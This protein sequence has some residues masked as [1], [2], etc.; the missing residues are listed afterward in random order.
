MEAEFRTVIGPQSA[1]AVP[2]LALAS[3]GAEEYFFRGALQSQ[4]GVWAQALVFGALH[5]PF[6][7]RMIAWPFFAGAVGLAF[8]WLTHWSGNLWPA[9]LAHATINH[10]NLSVIAFRRNP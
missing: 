6:N 5:V 10:V 3:A 4:I 1:L 8:G 2:L 9:I 7:A